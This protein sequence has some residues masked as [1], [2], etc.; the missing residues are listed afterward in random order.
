MHQVAWR[1]G[2]STGLTRALL[3]RQGPRRVAKGG[4]HRQ[5]AGGLTWISYVHRHERWGAALCS[6]WPG[7]VVRQSMV[8]LINKHVD[9]QWMLIN[10]HMSARH[11]P[12][13]CLAACSR[14]CLA[15]H[16]CGSSPIYR[17]SPRSSTCC[18]RSMRSL[19]RQLGRLWSGLQ[20]CPL[21]QAESS[22][23]AWALG[24]LASLPAV[25]S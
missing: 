7:L 18:M 22:A 19:P 3:H 23:S 12:V 8:T 24:W 2:F 25:P 15:W 6:A 16:R 13:A 9:K 20:A 11:M 14:R 1:P 21:Y 17:R 4:W 5:L 10:K